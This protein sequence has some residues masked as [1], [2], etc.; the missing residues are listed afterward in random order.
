MDPVKIAGIAAWPVTHQESAVTIVLRLYQLLQ[1]FHQRI[2]QGGQTHDTADRKR[3][4][5]VGEKRNRMP[6]KS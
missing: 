3:P 1:V 4:M 6:S 2:Q 5:D